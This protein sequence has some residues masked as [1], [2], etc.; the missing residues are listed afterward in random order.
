[1][2]LKESTKTILETCMGVL[3]EESVLIITDAATHP[4]IGLELY[5][6][7]KQIGCDVLLMTMEPRDHHAQEPP[8]AVAEA[9]KAVD[10][11]L[12]PTSKSLT[13]TQARLAAKKSGVRI[14]TMPGITLEMME[15]GGITADYLTVKDITST[16]K[17]KLTKAKEIRIVTDLG[18]DIILNVEGCDWHEDHGICHKAGSSTNLPAGEVFVAP[19]NAQG[20]FVV[21]G[22]MGGLGILESPLTITVKNRKAVDFTGPRADE[23]RYML[24]KVGPLARNLAE[25]GIGT[26]QAAHLIGNILEDEKVAGT[27]HIALGDNSTFGGDVIAGIHLDGIITKPSVF[28]DGKL[29]TLPA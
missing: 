2:T 11:L 5:S 23:L 19:K 27:V 25:L 4:S 12:I 26:N 28:V 29:L 20:I 15:S 21:D 18:T 6:T 24:D 8:V 22:S 9:M 3:P 1:M 14:A 13:H 7:A 17:K 10:V 16:L